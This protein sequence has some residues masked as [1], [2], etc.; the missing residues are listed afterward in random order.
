[1]GPGTI[2][3]FF[4]F[5]GRANLFPTG[6]DLATMQAYIDAKAPA[7]DTPYAVAPVANLIAHTIQLTNPADAPTQAA[8]VAE[9]TDMYMRMGGPGATIDV[10][11]VR[12]AVALGAGAMAWRLVVPNASVTNTAVQMPFI[13]AI[14]WQAIA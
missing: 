11:F 5:D 7:G 10:A 13:G 2:G 8:I 9:L 6:N 12:D 1:M 14:T 3:V 4:V